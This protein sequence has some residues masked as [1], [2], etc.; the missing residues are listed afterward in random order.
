MGVVEDNGLIGIANVSTNML[1]AWQQPGD[2]TG[3]PALTTG[4]TRNLLTDR[5]LEDASYL[6]LKNVSIGYELTKSVLK[7]GPFQSVRIYGQAENLLTWTKW[8]GFDPEFDPF[9]VNDF[10]TYP[11][12]RVF[13][14]GVDIKL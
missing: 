14:L 4:S 6:R 12:S 3:I 1:N 8:R 7:N 9:S 2:I 13:T 5:Y 11:N 10:F